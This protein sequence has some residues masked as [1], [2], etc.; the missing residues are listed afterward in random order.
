MV[1]K[2]NKLLNSFFCI[3]LCFGFTN[4]NT[5]DSKFLDLKNCIN[6][7][8]SYKITNDK[9]IFINN[10]DIFFNI[11]SNYERQLIKEKLLL[12]TD[13]KSYLELIT[14]L[15]DEKIIK[16][17]YNKTID[18]SPTLN[19]I[20]DDITTTLWVYDTCPKES[21]IPN[22]VRNIYFEIFRQGYPSLETIK[23]LIMLDEFKNEIFRL[24]IDNLIFIHIK[25][26]QSMVKRKAPPK[27]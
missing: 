8:I 9:N 7:K 10:K 13:K 16:E 27:F 12:G 23:K 18:D 5:S 2:I 25:Y 17:I 26:H 1:S 11:V 20:T 14:R 22:N 19:Y 3:F 6:E 24:S 4:C 15:K 21:N